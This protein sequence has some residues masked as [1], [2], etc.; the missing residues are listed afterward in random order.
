MVTREATE[1]VKWSM[2]SMAKGSS[3]D[4]SMLSP[5]LILPKMAGSAAPLS[6]MTSA[7]LE[8]LEVRLGFGLG[9]RPQARQGALP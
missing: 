8:W 5:M 2:G 6:A 9:L 1:V 3:S 4:C 7:G